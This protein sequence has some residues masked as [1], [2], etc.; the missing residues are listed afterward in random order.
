[1]ILKSDKPKFFENH[2]KAYDKNINESPPKNVKVEV[3]PLIGDSLSNN[4]N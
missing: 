1:L 3:K 4:R 2:E